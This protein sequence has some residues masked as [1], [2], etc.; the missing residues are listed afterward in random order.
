MQVYSKRNYIIISSHD[1]QKGHIMPA[2]LRIMLGLLDS[3]KNYASTI[4]DKTLPTCRGI[5]FE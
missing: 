3:A 4:I 2:G 1:S 5:R